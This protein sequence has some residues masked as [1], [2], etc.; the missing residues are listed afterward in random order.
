MQQAKILQHSSTLCD[1]LLF[2]GNQALDGNQVCN[3]IF[4]KCLSPMF[5]FILLV[6]DSVCY[7]QPLAGP[8][9]AAM[10]RYF[11]NSTSSQCEQ[12]TYGGCKGNMNNFDTLLS[13]KIR[14][15]KGE[16]LWWL[17]GVIILTNQNIANSTN[18]TIFSHICL[19]IITDIFGRI[20]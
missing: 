7:M 19:L 9:F 6:H 3:F 1:T 12:F 20:P 13:C 10:P 14:C 11:Y 18:R 5:S 2:N 17:P 15:T 16:K 8:C 4:L